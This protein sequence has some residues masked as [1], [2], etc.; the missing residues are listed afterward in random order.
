MLP[1]V[2]K[3]KYLQASLIIAI[4][5]ITVMSPKDDCH[6]VSD[7]GVVKRAHSTPTRHLK[8]GT[9]RYIDRTQWTNG[10]VK[11]ESSK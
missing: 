3:K 4:K 7:L 6:W 11:Q 10:P 5:C 8:S 9:K 1:F 2:N